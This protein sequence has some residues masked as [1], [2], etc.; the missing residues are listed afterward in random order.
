M[1]N[2]PKCTKTP[3]VFI[4]VSPTAYAPAA[5]LNLPDGQ[6]LQCNVLPSAHDTVVPMFHCQTKMGSAVG[7]FGLVACMLFS[8]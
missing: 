8:F 1:E 5:H 3:R 6:L 2:F 4:N 7:K